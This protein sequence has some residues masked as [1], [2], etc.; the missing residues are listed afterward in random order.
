MKIIRKNWGQ[1]IRKAAYQSLR[2]MLDM[3]YSISI[4]QIGK[5]APT[6][7]AYS[8]L[9]HLGHQQHYHQYSLLLYPLENGCGLYFVSSQLLYAL[10]LAS[11]STNLV[12]QLLCTSR[13]YVITAWLCLTRFISVSCGMVLLTI[14]GIYKRWNPHSSIFIGLPPK[15]PWNEAFKCFHS[16]DQYSFLIATLG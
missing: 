7:C 8:R 2:W 11:S 1:L 3:F 16:F 14:L 9:P 5:E 12:T 10:I 4:E 15:K 13:Y 6:I